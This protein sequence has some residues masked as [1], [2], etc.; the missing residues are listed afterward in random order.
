M[1]AKMAFSGGPFIQAAC[2]CDSVIEDKSGALSLIRIIDTITHTEAT[3][4]PPEE[5]PTFPF[6]LKMVLMLKSGKA[7]G[8]SNLMIVPELPTGATL[9]PVALTVHFDGEERGQ[10]VITN[11]ALNFEVEGL[12]WF[13]VYLDDDL[14]TAIPLRVK[15]NRVTAGV[16]PPES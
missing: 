1:E 7:R 14:F 5:M 15:Y 9:N 8:R 10:N 6:A 13:N 2:F 11:M 4:S 12:Y 3:P 16:K